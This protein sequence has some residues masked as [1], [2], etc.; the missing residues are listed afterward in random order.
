MLSYTF[1]VGVKRTVY[2]EKSSLVQL[3]SQNAKTSDLPEYVCIRWQVHVQ[4]WT[5]AGTL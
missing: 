1:V 4:G 2:A 3:L 5:G